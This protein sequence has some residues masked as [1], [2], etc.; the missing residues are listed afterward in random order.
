MSLEVLNGLKLNI[1]PQARLEDYTTFRLGG[2]CR[3]LI[4]CQTPQELESVIKQL[5][6]DK[7]PFILIGGGSNLVVSDE[8]IDCFVVRYVSPSP[9]IHREGNDLIVSGSTNLDSLALYAAQE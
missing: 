5:V 3:A 2:P 6:K 4:P 1:K 8:G 9:L 7:L